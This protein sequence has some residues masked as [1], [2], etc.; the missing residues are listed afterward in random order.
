MD[1]AQPSAIAPDH[2]LVVED[3]DDVRE[4]TRDALEDAGYRVVGVDNGASALQHL[5]ARK[6]LP[7]LIILDLMMP[8]MDGWG[9]LK[10]R[11]EDPDLRRVPVVVVSATPPAMT[12]LG[13]SAQAFVPKPTNVDVLLDTIARF[14]APS[15]G[16]SNGTAQA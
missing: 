2:I 15:G 1:T 13:D 16:A 3:D 7:R 4:A 12:R 5:R 14:M 11:D 8:V 9:F 6:G 10:V